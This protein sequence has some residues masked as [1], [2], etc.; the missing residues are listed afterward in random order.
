MNDACVDSDESEP[1]DAELE[2]SDSDF[3]VKVS[4]IRIIFIV[5]LFFFFID[6]CGMIL[7]REK[8]VTFYNKYEIIQSKKQVRTF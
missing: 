3:D 7:K 5:A 4:Y 6:N 8:N 2:G 1:D